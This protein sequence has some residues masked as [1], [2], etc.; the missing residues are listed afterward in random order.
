[1]SVP[2]IGM[3]SSSSRDRQAP[4]VSV[5]M[6]CLNESK[7]LRACVESLLQNDYPGEIDFIIIDGGSTDGTK[8][9][10]KDLCASD[11][12]VR[13]IENPRRTAPTALN[14]A[15]PLASGEIIIRV[16]AHARYPAN[17]ISSCVTAL[18]DSGAANVGGIWR[19][20]PGVPSRFGWTVAKVLGSRFGVGN[21][22]YRLATL[23]ERRWVDTVPF[24]CCRK[25]LFDEVGY[26]NEN[27]TRNQDI[28]F[29]RRIRNAGGGVLLCPE[30]EI[31]YFA[32]AELRNMAHH[33]W[34]TGLWII[35]PFLYTDVVA[36]SWRHLTPLAFVSS[37]LLC[38]VAAFFS[39]WALAA[40][41]IILLLY[42]CCAL[43]ASI[44]ISVNERDITYLALAPFVFAT[45]HFSYGVGSLCGVWQLASSS[46]KNRKLALRGA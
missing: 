18:L 13:M 21:A 46:F 16:D 14:L 9:I 29:N 25:S 37:L 5:L 43:M 33:A 2:N 11:G 42:I 24:L 10:I 28:E 20:V 15:I 17:Y 31:T 39:P 45:F 22:A 26:F 7:Y 19:V 36:I 38:V 44:Q 30:I 32:R 8:G 27:L 4:G 23:K 1:M 41:G 12:R 6:P 35:L 3:K 34:K 40:L